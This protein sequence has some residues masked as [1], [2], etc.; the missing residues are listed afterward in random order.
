MGPD[1]RSLPGVLCKRRGILYFAGEPARIIR[2]DTLKGGNVR[3][4]ILLRRG[5]FYGLWR[6]RHAARP[7]PLEQDLLAQLYQCEPEIVCH[8]AV[9][10]LFGLGDSFLVGGTRLIFAP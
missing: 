10:V 7:H 3:V 6:S 4:P 5:K 9:A 1:E 2:P 8:P